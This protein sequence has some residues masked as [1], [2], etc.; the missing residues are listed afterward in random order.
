MVYWVWRGMRATA[1]K[2]VDVSDSLAATGV[3]ALSASLSAAAVT[4]AYRRYF[5]ISPA[6]AYRMAMVKLNSHP[7]LLEIM[8]A[9]VVGSNARASV[10]TGGGIKFKGSLRPRLRSRRIQ[11]IFPLKGTERRGLVSLEAKKR[12]GKLK[13][14]L[15]AVDVPMPAVLGGEQRVYLEGGPKAY[16]RGGVLDELRRPFLSAIASD[17]QAEE[18]DEA[19]EE[20]EKRRE[21]FEQ[22]LLKE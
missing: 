15:L 5:S 4:F 14:S 18:A 20:E 17:D 21:R 3:F 6:A 13:L 2:F 22:G 9:P 7:G 12:A 8:G 11:M 1:A 10:M 16:S 19:E